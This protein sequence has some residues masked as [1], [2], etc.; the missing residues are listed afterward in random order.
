MKVLKN[1]VHGLFFHLYMIQI[2]GL[3][4]SGTAWGAPKKKSVESIRS[5]DVIYVWKATV[6]S[7]QQIS[8]KVKQSIC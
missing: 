1:L 6:H 3:S 4:A 5:H 8:P 2:V 7:Y